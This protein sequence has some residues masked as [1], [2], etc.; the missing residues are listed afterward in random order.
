MYESKIV[1]VHTFAVLKGA[2][3]G[4]DTKHLGSLLGMR[5]HVRPLIKTGLV[6]FSTSEDRHYDATDAG[7]TFYA[8]HRLNDLPDGRA[9]YWSDDALRDAEHALR[10][11][12]GH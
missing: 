11:L 12:E 9:N 5:S 10:A 2:V 4:D 3:E 8:E 7:R 6:E 1:R